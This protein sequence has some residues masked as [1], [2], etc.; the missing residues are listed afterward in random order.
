VRLKLSSVEKKKKTNPSGTR[1][2]IP[3]KHKIVCECGHL[4]GSVCLKIGYKE[5]SD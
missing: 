1:G 3:K 5:G 4:C 2:Q